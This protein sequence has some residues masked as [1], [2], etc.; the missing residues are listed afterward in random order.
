MPVHVVV[1]G[2]AGYLG[3]IL[4]EH[5]LVAGFR[6]T[7]VDGLIYRQRSL[8]HLCASARFDFVFG[9]ARDEELDAPPYQRR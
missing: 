5:L 8:F 3:S 1:T 6:V 7:A 2:A 9:D 4:C